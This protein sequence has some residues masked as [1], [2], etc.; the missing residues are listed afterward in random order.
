MLN[1]L[2]DIH[3]LIP[4]YYRRR[5]LPVVLLM[6]AGSL[7]DFFSL[8]TFLPVLL[9]IVNPKSTYTYTWIEDLSHF[10]SVSDPAQIAIY[11]TMLALAV[12]LVKTWV[13]A[14]IVRR[15]AA[16]AYDVANSLASSAL[17]GYLASSYSQ[18]TNTDYSREMNRISNYPLTFANNII[19]PL[20]TLISEGLLTLVLLAGL[21]LYK[22]KVVILLVIILMPV[23]WVYRSKRKQ[24]RNISDQ[25]KTVYPT[26]LKNTL[27]AVEALPEIKA[28]HKESFFKRKFDEVYRQLTGTFAT[29]HTTQ[30]AMSRITE[31][32]SAGCIGA[33]II[34]ALLDKRSGQEVI[35]LLS[36]F[37]GISFRIIP[38]A[39]R[40]FAGILQI[41]SHEY[42]V[43]ELKKMTV[44]YVQV[45]ELE[46]ASAFT[47]RQ[48]V[49]FRD[50][51]F[52]YDD[53]QPVLQ[54]VN[55]TVRRGER[56]IFVGKSGKGKTTLLL[57]LL[58]FLKEKSGQIVVDGKALTD[59]DALAWR[60]LLGYVPQSPYILDATIMENIAFGVPREDIDTRKVRHLIRSL[61]LESWLNGL[62]LGL[63]TIIGEKGLKISGGQRQRLAIARAL[64]HDAEILLLDEVTNQLDRE[65][66]KEIVQVLD[67]LASQH[68]TIF[69]VT[70][71]P[72]LWRSAD[73][74]YQ[75]NNGLVEKIP[76]VQLSFSRS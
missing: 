38:S 23:T 36:V 73:A 57:L 66:E 1:L 60:R 41:R 18:F 4:G 19:I 2:A 12:M 37:A 56:V 11:C 67:H 50:I 17:T 5:I 48:S 35:M 74:T 34:Y 20:G 10:M 47:F 55:F 7:L 14:W 65:T 42:V 43:S 30:A 22:V 59:A 9:L 31:L 51:A 40:I 26:V 25:I 16:Y 71:R 21:A 58:R 76:S 45:V 69:F 53:G 32:V 52:S 24:I 13:Q 33:L 39:N 3:K 8:A 64:Y 44:G 46:K 72:E 54:D 6:M 29:D 27:Q 75:I 63:D 49:E 70:H 28:F 15:K 61:D 62:T 68:K